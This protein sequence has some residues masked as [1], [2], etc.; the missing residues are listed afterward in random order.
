MTD[1]NLVVGIVPTESVPLPDMP[2]PRTFRIPATSRRA[3]LLRYAFKAQG[4]W[5][6]R[7]LLLPGETQVEHS[8][9]GP[10]FH[11]KDCNVTLSGT[12]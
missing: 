2:K 11:C 1:V 9:D 4:A 7:Q 5:I 10:P 6:K 8:N 3:G 12:T